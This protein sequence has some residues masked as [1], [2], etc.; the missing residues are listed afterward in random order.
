M[1]N[2]ILKIRI[3]L[4]LFEMPIVLSICFMLIILIVGVLGVVLECSAPMISYGLGG[5]M[6]IRPS[7]K[8]PNIFIPR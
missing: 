5:F 3:I 4:R 1:S 2:L 8:Y 7:N 6:N